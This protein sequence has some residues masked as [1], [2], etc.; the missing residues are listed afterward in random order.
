MVRRINDTLDKFIELFK[1]VNWNEANSYMIDWVE[2]KEARL[3]AYFGDLRLS[4]QKFYP[5]DK[6]KTYYHNHPWKK[7]MLILSG[8]AE[9]GI[10]FYDKIQKDSDIQTDLNEIVKNQISVEYIEMG[11]YICI[12]KPEMYHYI[13]PINEPVYALMINY[14]PWFSGP[15]SPKKIEQ[16]S[17]E[18][19]QELLNIIKILIDENN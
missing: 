10:S 18:D 8:K 15:K 1:S 12:D 14:K 7:E 11:S 19:K 4:I 9:H 16:I 6:H 5:C 2:P 17:I 13:W 3:F